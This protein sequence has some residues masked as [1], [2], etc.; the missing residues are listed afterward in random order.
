MRYF[1]LLLVF[2]ANL[3]SA[4]AQENPKWNLVYQ[5]E[6]NGELVNV[7][8]T[9]EAIY[10]AAKSNGDE[11]E[12]IQCF[13]FFSKYEQVKNEAYI[14]VVL[15]RLVSEKKQ[16]S[17]ANRGLLELIYAQLIA[18]LRH[19]DYSIIPSENGE[20]HSYYSWENEIV[21]AYH[22]SVA[23]LQASAKI[24]LTDY[25][26]ILLIA[27][28]HDLTQMSLAD[29]LFNSYR[30]Y[31]LSSPSYYR[32]SLEDKQQLVQLLQLDDASFSQTKNST[33]SSA[34]LAL[35]VANYQQY[36]S[37]LLKQNPQQAGSSYLTRLQ[38]IPNLFSDQTERTIALLNAFEKNTPFNDLINSSRLNRLQINSEKDQKPDLLACVAL[39]DSILQSDKRIA[40]LQQA[41]RIKHG[42]TAQHASMKHQKKL[43]S[44]QADLLEI[45]YKNTAQIQI[46]YYR[47]PARLHHQMNGYVATYRNQTKQLDSIASAHLPLLKKYRSQDYSLPNHQDLHSHT[48]ELLQEP[49]AIGHYLIE[50]KS[51]NQHIADEW[52]SNFSLVQVSNLYGYTY[53]AMNKNNALTVVNRQSGAP[54]PNV[55]IVNG[56]NEL[57]TD[58]NGQASWRKK[59]YKYTANPQP[60]WLIHELDSLQLHYNKPLKAAK[61]SKTKKVKPENKEFSDSKL[62]LFKDRGIYRPGQTLHYKAILFKLVD[63]KYI[64]VPY[65]SLVV[66]IEDSNGETLE[67]IVL[68]TNE[69]GSIIGN[70]T[71]PKEGAMG[72]YR[73]T[74]DEPNDYSGDEK[75]Y[76]EK[77]DTHRYW[78]NTYLD[79]PYS[80]FEVEEY[81]R[82]TF[83]I[84]FDSIAD[85][86]RIGDTIRLKGTAKALAGNA[87]ANARVEVEL[88]RQYNTQHQNWHIEN[89]TLQTTTDE[90]GNFTI[91]FSSATSAAQSTTVNRAD[92]NLKVAITN[93]QGET[94][95]SNKT[96]YIDKELFEL[97][98]NAVA[99]LFKEDSLEV[100]IT[101]ENANAHRQHANGKLEVYGINRPFYLKPRHNFPELQS[102]S[103]VDFKRH[104]PHSP[105]TN[106]DWTPER[107][108]LATLAFTTDTPIDSLNFIRS[109]NFEEFE[110]IAKAT[111]SLQN[112]IHTQKTI[113]LTS[114]ENPIAKNVL[115]LTLNEQQAK[116]SW[117]ATTSLPQ[118]WIVA[119]RY[120]QEQLVE[121][122]H[123]KM[124]QPQLILPFIVDIPKSKSESVKIVSVWENNLYEETEY[125]FVK[126]SSNE[127]EI[128]VESLR[129]FISP[130]AKETWRFQLPKRSSFE[131]IASMYDYSLDQFKANPWDYRLT[132]DNNFYLPEVNILGNPT[133]T[134]VKLS[135]FQ[136]KSIYNFST[137]STTK[138][139]MFGFDFR[140]ATLNSY[141]KKLEK[142][143]LSNAATT[144]YYGVVTDNSGPLPG[145][146]INI[147]GSNQESITD[148]DG[149]F[150]I[151]AKPGDTLVVD[152]IGYATQEVKLDSNTSL[153][154]LL[155]END[156]MDEI[157]VVAYGST[158]K[159]A[160][161]GSVSGV[162]VNGYFNDDISVR[163]RGMSSITK[164]NSPLVVIDGEIVEYDKINADALEVGN[165][166]ILK[167]ASATALYG[168]RG[169]NG[170]IVITTKAATDRLAA[171]QTRTNFSE[172]A[173]F[174]PEIKTDEHGKL[175]V[176][177]TAAED[178]TRWNFQLFA[179]S[180]K[181]EYGYFN[182]FITT[183]KK[184]MVQSNMPRFVRENDYITLSA[185]ISNLTKESLDGQALLQIINSE[186][187]EVLNSELALNNAL[188]T[189]HLLANGNTSVNWR[190]RVPEGVTA[191]EVK[192]TAMANDFSDGE[193]RML[194]VL[195]KNVLQRETE[196]VVI[197][198]QQTKRIELTNLLEIGARQQPL[199]LQVDTHSNW[200]TSALLALPYL[201]NFEHDCSEQ[202]F[203]RYYSNYI[204]AELANQYPDVFQEFM[205]NSTTDS[206]VATSKAEANAITLRET[207]WVN[208]AKS[209]A[210]NRKN[211]AELLDKKKAEKA[212]KNDWKQLEEKQLANGGFPWFEG[213]EANLYITQHLALK[214]AQLSQDYPKDSPNWKAVTQKAIDF[215]SQRFI[216][217]RKGMKDKK[218]YSPIDLHFLDTYALWQTLQPK[219]SPANAEI[220]AELNAIQT[221]WIQMSLSEK[222]HL[223]MALHYFKKRT[224]A[225]KIARNLEES[226]ARNDELGGYWIANS[227]GYFWHN[228]AIET[229]TLLMRTLSSILPNTVR[230]EDLK[231]WLIRQKQLQHWPSTQS[232]STAIQALLAHQSQAA[233]TSSNV[234]LTLGNREVVESL[235]EKVE[236]PLGWNTVI[237]SNAEITA[238]MGKMTLKN[239]GTA[240]AFAQATWNYL[241]PLEDLKASTNEQLH[242]EKRLYKKEVVNN[243]TQ[244]VP[245]DERVLKVGDRI[246]VR[247]TIHAKE[248]YEFIHLKDNRCATFEP[249]DVLSK[250]HYNRILPYRQVTK[251]A[252]THFFMDKL[253]KGTH[254]L[255]YD[256]FVSYPGEFQ[257]GHAQ[258][259]SMYAPQLQAH[260]Q[261]QKIK[262]EGN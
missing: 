238:D 63:T 122:L 147:V 159:E 38:I 166:T 150:S 158:K 15:E 143:N 44:Q 11:V 220:L 245:I 137:Y 182:H 21:A 26:N 81:K 73:I 251:D 88:N 175:W 207:P 96:V 135:S 57:R 213:G 189:V 12:Q 203:A 17:E 215:A 160:L 70:F 152:Y 116:T 25:K 123:L 23:N 244:Y 128:T 49:L 103:E 39:A 208:W 20:M 254:L 205:R 93:Q 142:R 223:A 140:K 3:F 110:I 24:P 66:E 216:E 153:T 202:T 41:E 90:K 256:V 225:E 196:V 247:L 250:Q 240:T 228:S 163:I 180:K 259:E 191:L 177:F 167:D 1:L 34:D 104:F 181:G 133:K 101:A 194:P 210:E 114:R 214:L 241:S 184:L 234:E 53:E 261:S 13:Y 112:Q 52:K 242:I 76:N 236:D 222:A 78:D 243:Q 60:T 186:T 117:I 68:Q 56:K 31:F 118:A 6:L 35:F 79:Y 95:T 27:P 255:E 233:S 219:N 36:E 84:Q 40:I 199:H 217:R 170:V 67:E 253:P 10:A 192:I 246:T 173:F 125:R 164:K 14:K 18:Q 105:Y 121:V 82:P 48:T 120:N 187:Q 260:S 97:K 171:V 9:V 87:I 132:V 230:N 258:I 108:L 165:M 155:S 129:D 154:I 183:Q 50:I 74:I 124:N 83:E 146:S 239:S 107:T 7:Q 37:I 138:L 195:S 43:H 54:V 227:G 47:I 113:Q 252:A 61:K 19:S 145:T 4:T 86:Y 232:T 42:L 262:V 94:R 32:L 119:Y 16:F 33:F 201:M 198:P 193:I 179:H 237:K 80:T 141:L 174:L 197:K 59:P 169:A 75:Y 29:F 127:I 188:Q 151:E 206:L 71:I 212:R 64:P 229:H 148:L 62:L 204:A 22:R 231:I 55:R 161:T 162:A 235:Q 218:S 98:I 156:V 115:K 130:G 168:N 30:A 185:N 58:A 126:N 248:Q 200:T 85:N 45:S 136:E 221:Q 5:Y 8:K 100:K 65:V 157:V 77:Q 109:L 209:A 131:A 99:T 149:Q 139:N 91:E 111:D 211:L 190:F 226:M 92:F 249:V 224:D 46:N 72:S 89:E 69:Y 134:W 106:D 2:C 51:L 144:R 176:E 28:T 257:D 172:T 178:L 102:I